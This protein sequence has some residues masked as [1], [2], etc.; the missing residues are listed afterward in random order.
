MAHICPDELRVPA[1]QTI[2]DESWRSTTEV[3]ES[4]MYVTV[5][6]MVYMLL[7]S[8]FAALMF[9]HVLRT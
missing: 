1:R 6:V 2:L 7:F 4:D 5:V 8:L 9:P 3:S